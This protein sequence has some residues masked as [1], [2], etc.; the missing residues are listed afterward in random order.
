VECHILGSGGAGGE[1]SFP[2]WNL[3]SEGAAAAAAGNLTAQ[4]CVF[5]CH[6]LSLLQPATGTPECTADILG[7]LGPRCW[8]QVH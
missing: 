7:T 1:G 4:P 2:Q 6:R 3:G 8:A 5:C